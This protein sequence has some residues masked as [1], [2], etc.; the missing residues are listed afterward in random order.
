MISSALDLF[1]TP[2]GLL[3]L[4]LAALALVFAA[5]Y[6]ETARWPKN[7]GTK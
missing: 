4:C 5:L 3:M 2:R 7:G 6:Y 1:T